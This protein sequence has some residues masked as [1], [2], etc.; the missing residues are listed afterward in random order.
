MLKESQNI[1]EHMKELTSNGLQ[2]AML[3]TVSCQV[4]DVL[5]PNLGLA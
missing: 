5:T 4:S 2:C 3:S 1:I